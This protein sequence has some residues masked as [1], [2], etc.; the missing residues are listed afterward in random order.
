MQR[1]FRLPELGENIEKGD[2]V[3]VLVSVGDLIKPDQSLVELETDKATFEVPST[4]SGKVQA[5]Y[6]K[7]GEKVKVGQL[8]LTVEDGASSGAERPKKAVPV[9]AAKKAAPAKAAEKKAETQ[10]AEAEQKA[11]VEAPPAATAAVAEAKSLQ[12]EESPLP[13]K[14]APA[15]PSVRRAARELGVDINRVPGSGPGG[16]ISVEDVKAFVRGITTGAPAV[17]PGLQVPAAVLPDF[18]RWGPV[19]RQ[20]M[21]AVR[22]KTAEHLAYAWATIPHVTQFDQADITELEELRKRFGAKAEASSGK[23]TVT[24]IALKVVA[25]A[26][27]RFPQFSA[28]IDAAREEIIYRRYY[29]VGVAVD[30]ERGLLVPVVRDVDRKNILELSA[31]LNAL[32]EKARQKQLKPEE[33]EGGVFTITNLGG[34]G[35]T[36]F[37]PIVNSPEVAILGISRSGL[38]P[39]YHDGHFEPRLM[40]PLSLSYDHRLID[41]AD[42]ARFLRWA[43]EAFEQLSLLSLE[44]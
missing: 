8:I 37:T 26:L 9:A 24:A 20:P 7:E 38:Q 44:G 11:E 17:A 43:A 22:R 42:A 5:I 15:A 32:A 19:E 18:S 13:T 30:T 2:L 23:L 34:I 27:K 16:R 4:I 36:H 21:R 35:G 28:A 25:S 41:G 10:V 40:L 12:T 29:H 14:I 3:K 1:E 33:M 31:E 39:V 6:V